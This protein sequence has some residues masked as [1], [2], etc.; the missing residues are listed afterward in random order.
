VGQ[1][2]RLDPEA[3]LLDIAA[4]GLA[5][6]DPADAPLLQP[7]QAVAES[8]RAPALDVLAHCCRRR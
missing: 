5:R 2:Q 7:L 6:L 8:K 4:R 1:R 3:S